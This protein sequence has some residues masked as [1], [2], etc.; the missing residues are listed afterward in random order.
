MWLALAAILALLLVP[1]SAGAEPIAELGQGGFPSAVTDAAGTLHAVWY[2]RAANGNFTAYCRVT[3]GGTAC[4]PTTLAALPQNSSRHPFVLLRPSDGVLLVVVTGYD[5]ATH[6]TTYLY[7]SADGGTTWARPATVGG[8][9]DDVVAAQLTPDGTAIDLLG[10]ASEGLAFQRVPIGA[11]A[12]S[13]TVKL[14]GP[15]SYRF[16][17]TLGT[18]PDGR[19]YVS[20]TSGGH[21]TGYRVFNGGDLY[22]DAA[23]TPWAGARAMSGSRPST[24]NGPSGAWLALYSGKRLHVL[25]WNGTRFAVP[26]TMGTLAGVGGG[27][28]GESIGI[29]DPWDLEVDLAG[30]VHVTWE[31]PNSLCSS[32]LCILYRRSEPSGFGPTFVYPLGR[33]TDFAAKS[34]VAAANSGG[35]GWIVWDDEGGRIRAVP[36][37]T[38]PRYS[39][40]GSRVLGHHRRV[41]GPAR[42]GCI[43]RGAP[44]VHRLVLDGRRAGVRIVSV[45]FFFDNGQLARVDRHEPY[46]VTYHLGFAPLSRHVAAARVTYRSGRTV[47]HTTIGRMIVMCP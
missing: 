31:V 10:D 26:R 30:R 8:G 23:W 43:R 2:E 28:V 45:R 37:V 39:R 18:L 32:F 47:R 20:A 12:E 11:G 46:R 25:R 9:L 15:S 38:P 33:T 13:R 1:S 19:P 4:Q 34:L 44:F 16:N 40:T 17:P 7:S 3:A 41:T 24:G 6:F 27:D 5:A 22:Q 42:S 14:L 29:A 21:R 36:L 35:S